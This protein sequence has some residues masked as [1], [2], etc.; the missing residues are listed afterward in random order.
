M[1][2][3]LIWQI[4]FRYLKGKRALNAVPILSRISMVAIAIGSAAMIV[5]FSVFNGFELVV[6]D[7]YKAFYPGVRITAARGKFFPAAKVNMA[8][9]QA[10]EGVE[11]IAPVLEDNAL[12][13]DVDV[14]GVTTNKQKVVTVKGIDNRYFQVN[15]IRDSIEG[16]DSVS[17]GNP[18][19]A[20]VGRHIA[21]ELGV[22][23]TNLF[24]YIMLYY[25][26][27]ALKN[28]EADPL[29]AFQSLKVHPAGVFTV[30]D[31]FD[32]K[33]VLAPISLV[34][35]LFHAPGMYS[36]IEISTQPGKAGTI[37]RHLQ[38]ML[39]PDYKVET[40]YEQNSTIYS[41]MA[42][43]KWVMYLI[44]VFVLVIASFNMVGALSMLVI[45][46]K[47]D[48]AILRAMG[49]TKSLVRRVFI[50]EGVLWALTGG[51]SGLVLGTLICLLQ[52]QFGIIKID[53]SFLVDA[54]P[55]HVA[56]PDIALVLATIVSVGLLVSWYPATKA[57]SFVEEGLKSN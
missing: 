31:E 27:P 43:E 4:A 46:K 18:Y 17:A 19:T 50:A 29:N 49:A 8:H 36:S 38:Q 35:D 26:N 56:L 32:D 25:P 41:M 33:F 22:D 2:L 15:N 39:G 11:H 57:A 5:L 1:E 37:K 13:G 44:L 48:I 40:Q 42:A 34:Q 9:I 53:G 10:I 55:V 16:D 47:K 30:S 7:M 51:V 3:R 28:P 14:A 20:I 21:H 54:Y 12:A 6:K 45:E 52:Q 24:G 23:M